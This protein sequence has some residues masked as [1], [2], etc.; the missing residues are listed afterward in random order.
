MKEKDF[1]VTLLGRI[2]N[3]TPSEM[4]GVRESI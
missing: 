2:G 4:V 1:S 3:H